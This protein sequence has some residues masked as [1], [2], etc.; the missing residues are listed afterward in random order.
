MEHARSIERGCLAVLEVDDDAVILVVTS[1]A[2][3]VAVRGAREMAHDVEAPAD[4]T[5]G[6]VDP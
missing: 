4:E 2:A 3:H 5:P 1:E 6:D